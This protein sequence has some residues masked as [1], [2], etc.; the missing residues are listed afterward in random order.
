MGPFYEV[1]T[2]SPGAELKPGES[3][4]HTQQVFHIQ[5]E[6]AAIEEIVR[7]LLGVGLKNITGRF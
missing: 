4:T 6:E 5:G 7:K 3:L 1:E 2:S